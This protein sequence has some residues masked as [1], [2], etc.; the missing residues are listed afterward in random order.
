LLS[1]APMIGHRNTWKQLRTT[2]SSIQSKDLLL[3]P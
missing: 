2:R 1:S 3:T